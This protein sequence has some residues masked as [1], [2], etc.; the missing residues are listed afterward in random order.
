MV[1]CKENRRTDIDTTYS[2]VSGCVYI[3]IHEKKEGGV[4]KLKITSV[5]VQ[6]PPRSQNYKG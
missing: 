5:Q 4:V 3:F 1:H 6:A 2:A